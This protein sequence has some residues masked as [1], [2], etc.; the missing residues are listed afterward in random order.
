ME[1]S[2]FVSDSELNSYINKSIAELHD[3]LIQAYDGEY[4]INSETFTTAN[5]AESYALST[6]VDSNNFYKIRGVDAKLNGTD[7]YTLK[8][9][10]FNER[11]KNQHVSENFGTHPVK[12]RLV[13]SNLVFTPIPDDGTE[14]KLWYIPS[15]QTLSADSDTYDDINGYSEYIV[16]DAAIKM[17]QKEESDV[18][19]L[20]AQ[21]RDLKRRI[22]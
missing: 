16:V 22:F 3:I 18:T 21:K 11:N 9:F 6:I 15:A 8:P 10:M 7:W 5:Q 2:E 1:N 14:V 4:Y 13:G 17:L 20:V 12:Y 19:V